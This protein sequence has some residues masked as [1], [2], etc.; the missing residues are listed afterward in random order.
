MILNN[1]IFANYLYCFKINLDKIYDIP[2]Q[3]NETIRFDFV[4][5]GDIKIK[6]IYIENA[7][8]S[9]YLIQSISFLNNGL[10]VFSFSSNP[11][12]P[13]S[14]NPSEAIFITLNFQPNKVSKFFDTLLIH[15]TEPFDFTYSI[16]IEGTSFIKNFLF[17]KDTSEFVGTKD[18]AIPI[19]LKGDTELSESITLDINF[20]VCTNSKVFLI[21]KV[22]NGNI[23]ANNFNNTFQILNLKINNVLFDSST[24]VVTY[25]IGKLLLAEQDTTVI[26]LSNV[27]SEIPG[28]TFS[29]ENGTLTLKGICVSDISLIDFEKDWVSITVPDLINSDNFKITFEFSSNKERNFVINFYDLLGSLRFSRIFSLEPEVDIPISVLPNGIYQL[30]ILFDKLKYSKKISVTK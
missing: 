6:T 5:L 3:S 4:K 9:T 8:T 16:P 20:S 18:F 13:V 28:I 27:D 26:T 1:L 24:K 11:N 15:F 22:S 30:E 25:L 2:L 12:V 17:I 21:E 14:L 19:Y 10:G 23:L 29:P 7:G